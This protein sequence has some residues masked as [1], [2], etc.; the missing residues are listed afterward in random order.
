MLK[1]KKL[2]SMTTVHL[3]LV[4]LPRVYL[5]KRFMVEKVGTSIPGLSL[6][7]GALSERRGQLLF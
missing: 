7:K 3:K 5:M 6:C 4:N 1:L 2:G